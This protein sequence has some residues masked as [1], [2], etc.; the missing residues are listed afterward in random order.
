MS[1]LA[2]LDQA[3]IARWQPPPEPRS[4]LAFARSM[5][6]PD[7]PAVGENWDPHT[8]PIQRVWVEQSDVSRWQV[9]VEVTPS[10]RGKSLMGVALPML[11]SITELRQNFCYVMPNL[12]KLDQNWHGKIKPMLEGCG[13]G[14]W[15]PKDGPGARGG[16]PAILTLRDPKT[17]QRAGN[18]YFM[19]A[20]GGGKETSLS[21]VTAPALALDEA[22]DLE[23]EGQV[24]LVFRR[25]KSFGDDFRVSIVSTVNDRK[26]R[27]AHPIL[28][29]YERGTQSRLWYAC[30]HCGKYQP[31]EWE[32]VILDPVSYTC[33]HCPIAWTEADR[34]RALDNYR[35][36]HK[37]QSVDIDGRVIGPEPEGRVFSLLAWDMEFH[38]AS[39]QAIVAEYLTARASIETRGD[40]SAMRQF[41][42]KVLCRDYHGDLDELE[43]GTELT[44]R[45]LLARSQQCKQFGPTISTKD[46]NKE[47][48]TE[49]GDQT[50]SRHISVV[51]E[52][53]NFCVGG[54]DL[55]NNRCYWSLV[56]FSLDL[57]TWD[58]AWGYEH[59]RED[60]M[61]W[62][63]GE[64]HAMLDRTHQVMRASTGSLPFEMGGL[65][66]AD[67]EHLGPAMAWLK[68]QAPTWVPIR[69]RTQDMKP[70]KGD[71]DG[72][73]Y[74]RNG[75][76][77]LRIDNLR[78]LI[79]AAYKRPNGTQGAAHI[80][81]GL[82]NNASDIAYLKH[83]VAEMRVFDI[84]TKKEKIRQGPGRWDWQ[85]ARRIAEAMGRITIAR[86]N[87]P[88]KKPSRVT[89]GIVGKII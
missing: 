2:Y 62:N 38:R 70:D 68:G 19:A 58:T 65:D 6:L 67:G 46:R 78:E 77:H 83:L 66:V 13:Y 71:I 36:V 32:Q 20:G 54:I 14:A 26:N 55:Q 3:S 5:T 47:D 81:Y 31:L 17:G 35:L 73:A 11:R 7:G 39:L 9:M 51:P 15:L 1:A 76:W 50:Y 10:Q 80:P 16:K 45:Y 42:H 74:L 53:G 8:E 57:T 61:P 28:L 64:L 4:S 34:Q 85:D 69:G 87:R 48:N 89:Y 27:D 22:D 25:A 63:V 12:E 29:F 86:M 60:H 37:G 59:A 23:S 21:S 44:W 24:G 82:S 49:G 79:H 75:E 56:A 18:L 72:I 43:L 40:H 30:P 88:P 41:H 33:L 84:K 52:G